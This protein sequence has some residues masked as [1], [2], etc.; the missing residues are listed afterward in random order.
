MPHLGHF[1]HVNVLFT[2]S[3]MRATA[4]AITRPAYNWSQYCNVLF[5]LF[6][7]IGFVKMS[8]YGA[9][10]STEKKQVKGLPLGWTAYIEEE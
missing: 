8:F 3:P 4:S 9:P 6:S 1:H 2:L 10:E 5:A 7:V